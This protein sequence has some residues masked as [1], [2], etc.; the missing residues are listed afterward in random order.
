MR[1]TF[2]LCIFIECHAL[3]MRIIRT[4]RDS[5]KVCYTFFFLFAP[6]LNVAP[7]ALRKYG[8]VIFNSVNPKVYLRM[9]R[10]K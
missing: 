2:A 8:K 1:G 3:C 4:E 5:C 9:A 6:G 10:V 7:P